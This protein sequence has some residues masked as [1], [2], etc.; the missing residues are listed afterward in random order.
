[1]PSYQVEA[2]R[3]IRAIQRS[4]EIGGR[5]EQAEQMRKIGD[6]VEAMQAENEQLRAIIS[7]ATAAVGNGSC[8]STQASIEFMA[9][10]PKEIALNSAALR[11]E[12]GALKEG[13]R[14]VV[15][16][17][18]RSKRHFPDEFRPRDVAL[19]YDG[20]FGR[21]GVIC[22]ELDALAALVGEG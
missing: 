17:Y 2:L 13:V 6:Q 22:L 15:E 19:E 4:H 3:T 9:G 7:E 14:P 1:M 12:L 21:V 16:W 11:A 10:L 18:T 5:T 8:C 20:P